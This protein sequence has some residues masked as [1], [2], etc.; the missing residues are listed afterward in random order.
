MTRHHPYSSIIFDLTKFSVCLFFLEIFRITKFRLSD[1]HSCTSPILCFVH[2]TPNGYLH[3]HLS[4][5]ALVNQAYQYCY[6]CHLCFRN[7]SRRYHLCRDPSP[8]Q[9]VEYQCDPVFYSSNFIDR[10]YS[11]ENACRNNMIWMLLEIC[12]IFSK[13]IRLC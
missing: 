7:D 9:N 3:G 11:G 1:R 2:P 10:S 8:N 5:V 4:C 6:S 12:V 13:K